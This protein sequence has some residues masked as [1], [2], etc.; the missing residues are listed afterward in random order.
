[1]TFPPEENQ[2][3]GPGRYVMDMYIP[4]ACD[5]L[6]P[7]KETL[8]LSGVLMGGLHRSERYDKMEITIKLWF[9][10]REKVG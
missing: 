8:T 9:K 10:G 1:M 6:P 2:D 7:K 4:I 3:R 5:F